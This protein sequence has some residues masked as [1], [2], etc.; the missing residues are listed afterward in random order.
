VLTW[1]PSLHKVDIVER[2]PGTPDASYIDANQSTPVWQ[3]G[4]G[5]SNPEGGY[6]WIAPT[7][8]ARIERPASATRFELKVMPNTT[9]L[10]ASGA[11]TVTVSLDG[12]ELAPRRLTA[13]GWQTLTWDVAPAAAGPVA[14]TIHSDPPFRPSGDPRALG[15]PVGGVG[16]R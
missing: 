4:D 8:G 15:I 7:A 9:I 12:V 10:Q 13:I 3:L 11:V 1:N 6:R 5:W 2:G 14:V 16:F